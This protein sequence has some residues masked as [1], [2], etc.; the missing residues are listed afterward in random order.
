VTYQSLQADEWGT[1]DDESF[2][3]NDGDGGDDDAKTVRP[4]QEPEE[5]ADKAT[6]T[7]DTDNTP[8][9]SDSECYKIYLN[10]FGWKLLI[11]VLGLKLLH[12][13]LE[14]MP[15]KLYSRTLMY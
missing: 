2:V 15:R 4:A 13:A 14:A 9:T 6:P 1:F 12:T 5:K 10:S 7:P 8:Q 11:L 3:S